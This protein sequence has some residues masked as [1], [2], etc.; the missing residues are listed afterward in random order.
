MLNIVILI[1]SQDPKPK[2]LDMMECNA[3]MLSEEFERGG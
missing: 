3:K 2:R 1:E